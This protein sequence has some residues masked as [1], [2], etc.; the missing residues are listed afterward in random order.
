MKSLLIIKTFYYNLD[1][2]KTNY[3]SR[4]KTPTARLK[5]RGLIVNQEKGGTDSEK[6]VL[7][8]S[9]ES[10]KNKSKVEK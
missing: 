6:P 1:F 7:F 2:A 10:F 3:C 9:K 4:S 8:L 5:L